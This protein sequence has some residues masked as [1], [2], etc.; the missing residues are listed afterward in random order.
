METQCVRPSVHTTLPTVMEDDDY[1]SEC[2][3]CNMSEQCGEYDGEMETMTLHR[4]PHDET[5]EP[6]PPYR[7]S[8]T[9]PTNCRRQRY[10]CIMV[11]KNKLEIC[12]IKN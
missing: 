10:C 3:N 1:R 8:L 6:F 9:L 11:V 12:I 7:T 5:S 4:R 2:E